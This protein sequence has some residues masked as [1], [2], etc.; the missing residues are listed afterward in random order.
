MLGDTGQDG[1][2]AV[3]DAAIVDVDAEVDGLPVKLAGGEPGLGVADAGVVHQN[4]DLA[5]LGF[6]SVGSLD[7]TRAI[8]DVQI[9]AHD[10]ET[11]LLK[12]GDRFVNGAL[13]E[14]G[15]GDIHAL[16]GAS[17]G[18]AQA[19]AAGAAGDKCGF[20]FQIN[21]HV[22]TSKF[23]SFD[24]HILQLFCAFCQAFPAY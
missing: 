19:H 7:I 17:L 2:D 22:D 6:H 4:M 12:P 23:D 15:D 24:V 13:P 21:E 18:D 20:A 10:G 11:M 14:V 1:A 3:Q 9:D 8:S 16:A 5:E